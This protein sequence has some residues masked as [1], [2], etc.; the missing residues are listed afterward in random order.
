ML[1]AW[2]ILA[3]AV[4]WTVLSSSG[5]GYTY[6]LTSPDGLQAQC[7]I[8]YYAAGVASRLHVQF[9]S[10]GGSN[11]GFVHNLKYTS[12]GSFT[13]LKLWMNCCS[14]F[15]GIVGK[16]PDTTCFEYAIAAGI[17]ANNITA[18]PPTGPCAD[19]DHPLLPTTEAWFSTS[20]MW[21]DFSGNASGFRG[22]IYRQQWGRWSACY[23]GA[24]RVAG[25][26]SSPDTHLGDLTMVIPAVPEISNSND[27]YLHNGLIWYGQT[28]PVLADAIVAWGDSDT[29]PVKVRGVLWDA[30]CSTGPSPGPD[31]G[32]LLGGFSWFA[33]NGYPVS[34]GW[35]SRGTLYLFVPPGPPG[36]VAY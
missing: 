1:T 24:V 15:T 8:N 36:N 10:A 31:A 11:P 23:N 26:P 28:D 22:G 4:G 7:S 19:P 5:T 2:N 14:I 3:T 13:Q 9:S 20:D 16:M 17:P 30:V 25:S 18:G 12:S 27:T 21:T 32:A 34:Q 35:N 29:T 33:Y 6:L